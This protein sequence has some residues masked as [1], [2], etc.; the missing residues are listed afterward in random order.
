MLWLKGG[1]LQ[2]GNNLSDL[3]KILF[4]FYSFYIIFLVN[5]AHYEDMHAFK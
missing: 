2:L 3:N 1:L 5:S 4:N